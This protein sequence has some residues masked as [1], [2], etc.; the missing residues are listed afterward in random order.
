MVTVSATAG[1]GG[2]A[3]I[4]TA[5]V[6]GAVQ[7]ERAR[8]GAVDVAADAIEVAQT[9]QAEGAQVAIDAAQLEALQAATARLDELLVEATGEEPVVSRDVPASRSG[10]RAAEDVTATAPA[11]PVA[12]DP[13]A[14]IDPASVFEQTPAPPTVPLVPPAAGK[15]DETTAELREAVAEVATLTSTVRQSAEAKRVAD[16][17]AAAQAAAEAAAAQAAADA[18]AQAV[19]A[20]Q[21]QRAAWKQSLLGYANGKIPDSALCGV[22]FDASVRLRCDAAEQLD[23]L[24]VAYRAQFGSDLVVNDSYRSYAGQVACKRTKGYLCATPG[25]SNHGSGIAVDLG[26]GIDSFGTRQHRWMAAHAPDLSWGLPSWAAWGGSKPE[27]WHW[28]YTG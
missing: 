20:Q 12:V 27:A 13:T 26:G 9:V 8:A 17:A 4:P 5:L 28:E 21:A 25:T 10:D 23:V 1:E 11:A 19:A 14:P 2:S 15:E 22:S 16:T 18:A 6:P 24:N 7:V 3:L